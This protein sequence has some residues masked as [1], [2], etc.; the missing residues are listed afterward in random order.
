MS[1]AQP[2]YA[3]VKDHIVGQIRSGAWTPGT[4]VPSE[5]ELVESFGISRMTA[6]RALREHML[7]A[8]PVP[9]AVPHPSLCTDNGAMIAMCGWHMFRAGVR[10]GW[11]LDVGPGLR[12]GSGAWAG[13]QTA[14]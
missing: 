5:N 3:K 4:R 13:V 12:V 7:V 6:N 2:L 14:G 8:S 1:D 11:D 9:V 10:S